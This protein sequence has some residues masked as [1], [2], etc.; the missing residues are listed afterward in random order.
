[1]AVTFTVSY[2]FHLSLYRADWHVKH[3]SVN[4]IDSRL[5]MFYFSQPLGHSGPAA[6]IRDMKAIITEHQKQGAE[7]YSTFFIIYISMNLKKKRDAFC[8]LH[9]IH[10]H[11]KELLKDNLV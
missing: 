2:P 9:F 7:M 6:W 3:S 11:H 8:N 5:A 10:A 1:M 4:K